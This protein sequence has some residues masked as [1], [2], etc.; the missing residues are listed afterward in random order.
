MFK[1]SMFSYNKQ[2]MQ[3]VITY[4]I[5]YMIVALKVVLLNVKG[6]REEQSNDKLFQF[7]SKFRTD[8]VPN[9]Q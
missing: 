4:K 6:R 5:C 1:S 8:L 9:V 2:K 7:N 3:L